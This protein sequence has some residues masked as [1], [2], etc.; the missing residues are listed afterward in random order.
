MDK[1][2]TLPITPHIPVLSSGCLAGAVGVVFDLTGGC[3]PM[4]AAV[5][6]GL[7]Q[8]EKEVSAFVTPERCWTDARRQH[9]HA[10][11]V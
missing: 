5:C 7:E 6:P 11:I 10:N 1:K 4:A 2:V 9:S 8:G 3:R